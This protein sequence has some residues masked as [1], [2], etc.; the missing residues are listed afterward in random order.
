MALVWII[1]RDASAVRA[2][3]IKAGDAVTHW[4]GSPL[5]EFDGTG[6]AKSWELKPLD[7]LTVTDVDYVVYEEAGF[8]FPPFIVGGVEAR[9]ALLANLRSGRLPARGKRYGT[10]ERQAIPKSDWTDLTGLTTR[11]P[12]Q[13]RSAVARK[14]PR[15]TMR[16]ASRGKGCAK[17]GCRSITSNPKNL[18]A[19]TGAPTMPSCGSLIGIQRCFT[20]SD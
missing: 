9:G 5:A 1:E 17:S 2:V 11:R 4:V 8:M 18:S 3:W 7:R 20:S 19:R 13:T 15:N 10:S 14:T 6:A 12:R 16:S